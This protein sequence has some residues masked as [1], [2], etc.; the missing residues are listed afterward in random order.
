MLHPASPVR[1]D[2][3]EVDLLVARVLDDGV[4]R[5]LLRIARAPRR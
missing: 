1:A 3:D 4:G 2:D 5:Q